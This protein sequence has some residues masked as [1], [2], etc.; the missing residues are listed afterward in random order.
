MD[1]PDIVF[2]YT[3]IASCSALMSFIIWRLCCSK[4]D[5]GGGGDSGA[6][7]GGGASGDGSASGASGHQAEVEVELSLRL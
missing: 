2:I 6:S 5:D 4:D 7:G 3:S 1:V